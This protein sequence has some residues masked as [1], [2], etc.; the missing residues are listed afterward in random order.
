MPELPRADPA[1]AVLG[2]N[3]LVSG[4]L[5]DLWR[6]WQSAAGRPW[7]RGGDARIPLVRD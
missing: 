5:V 6:R 3:S 1:F 4:T 7:G 2:G